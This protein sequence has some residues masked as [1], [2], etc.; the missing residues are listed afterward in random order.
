ML[1]R[2]E[3][4]VVSS[5]WENVRPHFISHF[6]QMIWNQK[7]ILI[8]CCFSQVSSSFSSEETAVGMFWG[9]SGHDLKFF[10]RNQNV[11]SNERK[12]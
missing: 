10:Q 2:F 4:I 1:F 3:E 8:D 6:H 7:S 12:T 9:I 11:K 5:S